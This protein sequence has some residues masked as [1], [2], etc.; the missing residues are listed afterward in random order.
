MP[1]TTTLAAH[2]CKNSHT[3]AK[4]AKT[5]HYAHTHTHIYIYANVFVVVDEHD[6]DAAT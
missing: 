2:A 1:T 5:K 6:D 4:Y 3:L